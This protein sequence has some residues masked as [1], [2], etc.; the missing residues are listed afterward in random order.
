M[1][2]LEEPLH[3]RKVDPHPEFSVYSN[4]NKV[5]SLPKQKWSKVL[6][7]PPGRWLTTHP[8]ERCHTGDK[9]LAFAA[10]RWGAEQWLQ[11]SQSWWM[12]AHVAN[13]IHNLRP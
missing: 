7:L 4:K 9:V 5:L 3:T 13:P 2:V 6:N 1:I 10:G 12:E 8:G 11:P